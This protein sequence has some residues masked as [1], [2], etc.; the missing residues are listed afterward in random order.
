MK[1]D[2]EME[3]DSKVLEKAKQYADYKGSSVEKLAEDFLKE[4]IES[5]KKR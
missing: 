3:I 4:L 1:E 2:F 5:N